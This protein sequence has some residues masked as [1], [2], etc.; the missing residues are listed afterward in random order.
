[1]WSLLTVNAA[2]KLDHRRVKRVEYLAGKPAVEHQPGEAKLFP[3][4]VRLLLLIGVPGLF[5][6]GAILLILHFT[7]R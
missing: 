2:G 5:W 3:G 4:W 6:T 1:M 7:H